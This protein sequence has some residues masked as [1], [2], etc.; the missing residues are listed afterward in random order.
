MSYEKIFTFY[1]KV[2]LIVFPLICTTHLG[3]LFPLGIA[4]SF[5]EKSQ[6]V[7]I[8]SLWYRKEE[9]KLMVYFVWGDVEEKK[10]N[11]VLTF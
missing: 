5:G 2:L 3:H 4:E 11:C 7:K 1:C 9:K 6:I 10:Q 8:T